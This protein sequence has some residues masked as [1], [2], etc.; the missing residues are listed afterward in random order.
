MKEAREKEKVKRIV[1][2]KKA[3]LG[4]QDPNDDTCAIFA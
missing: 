4:D 3:G 2:F 1:G